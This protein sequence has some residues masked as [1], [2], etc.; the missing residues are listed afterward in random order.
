MKELELAAR[1]RLQHVILETDAAIL[2]QGLT[3]FSFDR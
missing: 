2:V 3:G 1:L